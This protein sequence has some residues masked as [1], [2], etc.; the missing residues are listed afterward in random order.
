[1]SAARRI[2]SEWTDYDEEMH[3][4][5]ELIASERAETNASDKDSSDENRN[6]KIEL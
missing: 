4:L 5:G 2:V 6:Q 1:M 3:R